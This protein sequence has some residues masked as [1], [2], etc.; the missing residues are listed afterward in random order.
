MT[1]QATNYLSFQKYFLLFANNISIHFEFAVIS[2]SYTIYEFTYNVYMDFRKQLVYNTCIKSG[3]R[4]FMNL[5]SFSYVI[6]IGRCGSINR[7]AQNLYLSQSNL[8]SSIRALEDELGYQIFTRTSRG[9]IPTAEG[10]LFIQSAKAILEEI[11]KIYNVPSRINTNADISL[12]C[13]WSSNFL[14][15]FIEFK[16]NNHPKICD[17][18]K[19][20]GLIQNFQDVQENQY[21]MAI[22]Y[23]FHSRT[24]HHIREAKQTNLSVSLLMENIPAVTLVSREHPLAKK[25]TVTLSDIHSYPLALFENFESADWLNVLR[26]PISQQILYL[27]DRGG[28]VD[29]LQNNHYISVTKQGA[30]ASEETNLIEIPIEDL[31]DTLDVLLLKHTAYTPNYRETAFLKFFCQS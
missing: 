23:C 30:I 28:I 29:A 19:E 10:Y 5:N 12:S 11:D 15:R 20:T 3:R 1:K 2:N 22:F 9:I 7:A 8:S 31:K 26:I 17:S 14:R 21:R 25:E 13:T 6:E 16:A 27:F 18:Y 24:K 4:H